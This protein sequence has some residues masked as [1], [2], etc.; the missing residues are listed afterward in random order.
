[1]ETD[2]ASIVIGLA[3]IATFLIPIGYYQMKEKN[4]VKKAKNRFLTIAEDVGFQTG[5]VDV[6]RNRAAIGI[7]R[8]SEELLYVNHGSHE[9]IELGNIDQALFYKSNMQV[10]GESGDQQNIQELGIRF[11]MRTGNDVKL[12]V[13]EGRDGTQIGDE[14]IIVQGWI[15]KI[16]SAKRE[17]NKEV[18]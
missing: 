8:N 4:G 17:L 11:K 13:F 15:H 6:L 18:A 2:I 14:R 9:L 7:D 16:E 1:M 12:P 5:E 3:S 10:P